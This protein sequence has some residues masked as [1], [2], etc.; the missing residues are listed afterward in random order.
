MD[1]HEDLQEKRDCRREEA[2]KLQRSGSS[3]HSSLMRELELEQGKWLM[4]F[5]VGRVGTW[6]S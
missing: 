2:H 6:T 1:G 3:V 5:I 4:L